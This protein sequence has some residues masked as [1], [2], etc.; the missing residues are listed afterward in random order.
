MVRATAAVLAATSAVGPGEVGLRSGER[1]GPYCLRAELIGSRTR[2]SSGRCRANS[3]LL[4][5]R[6]HVSSRLTPISLPP[7]EAGEEPFPRRG[8]GLARRQP[9]GPRMAESELSGGFSKPGHRCSRDG[10]E[11]EAQTEIRCFGRRLKALVPLPGRLHGPTVLS[12]SPCSP[13][14]AGRVG[15]G[16]ADWRTARAR[17]GAGRERVDLSARGGERSRARGGDRPGGWRTGSG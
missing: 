14:R 10:T 16:G 17:G 3:S 6:F 7:K 4:C 8:W 11:K 5:S 15:D 1:D 2:C 9:V 13:I 12:E